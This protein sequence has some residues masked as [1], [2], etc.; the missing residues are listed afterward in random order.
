[1]LKLERDRADNKNI[2]R[3]VVNGF[4]YTRSQDIVSVVHDY[5]RCLY[6]SQVLH[7]K[8]IDDLVKD[9]PRLED[10]DLDSSMCEGRISY[11][12]C[13]T[14]IKTMK[15]EKS[16]GPDGLSVEFYNRFFSFVW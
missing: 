11:N 6:K 8:M 1:L 12:E 4:E 5:Y 10:V 14:A 3:I 2:D 7:G 16:P 13:L 9:A 15:N